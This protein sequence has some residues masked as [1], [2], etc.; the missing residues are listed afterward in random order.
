MGRLH[1][2]LCWGSTQ[3]EMDGL[4]GA[5]AMVGVLIFLCLMQRGRDSMEEQMAVGWSITGTGS[6]SALHHQ[7]QCM[8]P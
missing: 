3:P 6:T 2:P 4:E 5:C 7:P 1:Q 8:A